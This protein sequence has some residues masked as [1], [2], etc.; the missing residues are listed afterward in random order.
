MQFN[1]FMV[2][3]DAMIGG[4]VVAILDG[5]RAYYEQTVHPYMVRS[6]IPSKIGLADRKR[7]AERALLRNG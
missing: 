6:G 2:L 3:S 5:M 1:Q 4:I 7:H